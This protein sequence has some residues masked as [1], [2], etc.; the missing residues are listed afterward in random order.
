MAAIKLSPE[1]AQCPTEGEAPPSW[2]LDMTPGFGSGTSR[3]IA[4]MGEKPRTRCGKGRNH[5]NVLR[6]AARGVAADETCR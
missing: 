3:C 2:R 4:G 1:A 5:A 6:S